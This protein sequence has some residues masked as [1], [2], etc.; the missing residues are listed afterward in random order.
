MWRK[1]VGLGAKRVRT[2]IGGDFPTRRRRRSKNCSHPLY[3]VPP[4]TGKENFSIKIMPSCRVVSSA[5]E[6][7]SHTAG[8][9]GSIPV[10][11]TTSFR[12]TSKM[13]S[14]PNVAD[15]PISGRSFNRGEDMTIRVVIA[16][17]QR[18]VRELLAALLA[19]EWNLSVVGEASN[20]RE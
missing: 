16:E 15:S 10:R 2:G 18:M 7:C 1:P 13:A 11:P 3:S 5:V 12:L 20:G 4:S 14:R 19:R 6:H 9:T 17:D 8:A